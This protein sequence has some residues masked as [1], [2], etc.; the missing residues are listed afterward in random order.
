VKPPL[1]YVPALPVLAG[2][3][4]GILLAVE[5]SNISWIIAIASIVV[6]IALWMLRR[7][8]WSSLVVFTAVGIAM[9]MMRMPQPLSE[10]MSGRKCVIS[11]SIV[12]VSETQETTRYVLQVNKYDNVECK[13]RAAITV[14][15]VEQK[16]NVGDEISVRGRLYNI[17]QYLD[18]P[19]QLDY[20]AYAFIDGITARMGVQPGEITYIKSSAN[21]FQ[22][23]YNRGITMLENS[24]V[25]SGFNSE[26]SAFLLATIAGDDLLL[27][28]ELNDNFRAIGLAHILALSGLHV[29]II[30]A[31]VAA[32]LFC[33][34]CLPFGRYAYYILLGAAVM[35]YACITGMSPSVARAAVMVLV[36]I[37]TKL[38]QRSSSVYNSVCVTVA[39][40]LIIN[41]FWLW[42]PGLQLSVSA[43]LAI[44]WLSKALNP[45]DKTE[46]YKQA[47]IGMIIIP[48]A[49]IVGT[50]MLTLCYFHTFP[51]WFLPSNIIAG[52][53]S[54]LIIGGGAIATAL[55]ALGISPG[56]LPAVV[57][58]LYGVLEKIVTW[59]AQLPG[60]QLTD[61]YPAWWQLVLY[62][63][64]IIVLIVAT[65]IHRKAYYYIFGM[66]C[67]LLV[68]TFAIK[69][70]NSESELFVP[71]I[72]SSTDILIRQSNRALLISNG[73]TIAL[74][75][76]QNMYADY[77]GRRSAKLE[78]AP[79]SFD[80]GDFGRCNNYLYFG[81]KVMKIVTSDKDAIPPTKRIDY[82]LVGGGFKGDIVQLAATVKADTI[83]LAQSINA[84]RRHRYDKELKSAHI[85]HYC[86]RPFFW[87]NKYHIA[88]KD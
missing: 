51:L 68:T 57:N 20:S 24:I 19:D 64:C 38:M 49:A 50:S 74:E 22:K 9:T 85:S 59:F 7:N 41:P 79:D 1:S 21:F 10:G 52:I 65:T 78:L 30:M 87:Q 75:R 35:C 80:L 86:D 56:F 61:L 4:A 12:K 66:L 60:G 25:L 53:L 44:V 28:N 55:T 39:I 72:T 83:I 54:P 36:Y 67:I 40:W 26:T 34:R 62:A 3:S 31:I 70:D 14:Y 46:P 29:G 33:I 32:L 45:Y 69:P 11:G 13:F 84:T 2:L 82:A 47:A 88:K 8:W 6:G 76:A 5:L 37:A 71:R 63:L 43:V 77:L 15:S 73:D 23:L 42:S 58:T 17:E 27:T 16:Y 48:I 81:D 18:V